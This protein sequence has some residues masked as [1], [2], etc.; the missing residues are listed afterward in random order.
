DV[1]LNSTVLATSRNANGVRIVVKT[2]QGVKLILAKKLLVSIPPK[3]SNFRGFDLSTTEQGLFSQFSNGGYYTG[4]LRNTG[5]PDNILVNNIGADTP[6][7]LPAVPGSYAF[8]PTLVP[9]LKDLKVGTPTAVSDAELKALVAAEI[10]RLKT[11]G[12]IT[13]ATTPEF[14]AYNSHTPYELRVSADAIQAGFY[15]NLNALQG[16]KNTWWTGA[17]FDKHASGEIWAFTATLLPDI[18]A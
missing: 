1:F 5:I 6:Y 11:A 13:T 17:A 8:S 3:L 18:A 4:L 10:E 16:H 14:V 2:P 7:N 12:T 9:G 15:K